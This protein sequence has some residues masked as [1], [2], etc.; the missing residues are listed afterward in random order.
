MFIDH[1]EGMDL[2]NAPSIPPKVNGVQ[3]MKALEIKK[4]GAW[5][6]PALDVCME[7]QLRNPDIEDT[8]G[9]IEEVKKRKVELKIP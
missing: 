3:L 9:A 8:D 2:M 5:M 4:A 7:W 6:K 1:L